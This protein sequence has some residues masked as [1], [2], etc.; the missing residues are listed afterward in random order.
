MVGT[1]NP[2]G[3]RV[4]RGPGSGRVSHEIGDGFRWWQQGS[5]EV[6]HEKVQGS[7]EVRHEKGQGFAEVRR[8]S[9]RFGM[10]RG[11]GPLQFGTK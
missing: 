11:R 3:F 6:R 7:G 2:E 8:G 1:G 9:P 5:A 4:N 10:K